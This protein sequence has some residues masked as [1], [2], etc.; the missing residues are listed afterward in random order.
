MSGASWEAAIADE[1][2]IL[3]NTRRALV[4][5]VPTHYHSGPSRDPKVDFVGVIDGGR[6][7]ALEAKSQSGAL[8]P[9]QRAYLRGVAHFGGL[10]LVYRWIDGE[11]HL[12]AVDAD[13]E[14][15]RKSK[16]TRITAPTWLD[17]VE[18]G[19]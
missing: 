14:I 19:L 8:T 18:E 1:N 13:G 2:Q 11:R 12:C 15:Q 4:T 3:F 16:S 10:A 7:V 9:T 6:F 17:A 5:R